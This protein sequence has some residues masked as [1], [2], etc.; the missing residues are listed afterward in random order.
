MISKQ[1]FGVDINRELNQKIVVKQNDE[2][3]RFLELHLT[4]GGAVCN[5]TGTAVRVYIQKP[6]GHKVYNNVSV[7][8]ATAGVVLVPLTS[9]I[10]ALPG[11]LKC[12]LCIYGDSSLLSNV[13]FSVQVLP[14]LHEDSVVVSSDEFSALTQATS[15]LMET[16]ARAAELIETMSL[17]NYYTKSE[18]D[19]A[20]SAVNT[21]TETNAEDISRIFESINQLQ[22]VTATLTAL[23]GFSLTDVNKPAVAIRQGREV[24]IQIGVEQPS[25]ANR[26]FTQLPQGMYDNGTHLVPGINGNNGDVY[27]I[28]ID[29]YGRVSFNGAAVRDVYINTTFI[30]EE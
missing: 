3:S 25:A 23:N 2:A 10:L 27:P 29:R 22:P 17:E 6:D 26:I 7:T 28:S 18:V 12:E 14:C 9:Q 8:D 16:N 20:V 24:H 30:L 21:K 4:D 5:L 19:S 1:T 11:K 15:D 13:P